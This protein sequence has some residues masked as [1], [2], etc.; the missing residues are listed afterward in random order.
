MTMI[1]QRQHLAGI[2]TVHLSR[3]DEDFVSGYQEGYNTYKTYHDNEE[4]VD[5]AT[6]LFLIKNGGNAGRSDPWNTGYIVGWLAALYEQEDRLGVL[7]FDE[8]QGR[9]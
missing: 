7:Y 9:D 8:T 1:P 6:L 3:D 4:G 2:G 5:T